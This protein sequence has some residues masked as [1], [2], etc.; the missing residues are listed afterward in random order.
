MHT[1]TYTA[2]L[3]RRAFSTQ[4][5]ADSPP[6][7]R[8]S[9]DLTSATASSTESHTFFFFGTAPGAAVLYALAALP[10]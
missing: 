8:M 7:S 4:T 6:L 2:V 10:A 3:D 5:S 9:P 1:F